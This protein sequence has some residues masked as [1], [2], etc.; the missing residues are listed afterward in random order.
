[1]MLFAC[2]SFP[3]FPSPRV[4][5]KASMDGNKV[6]F[7]RVIV[8][9]DLTS[10]QNNVLFA[11]AQMREPFTPISRVTA[12]PITPVVVRSGKRMWSV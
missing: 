12:I 3:F 6:C 4:I 9:K 10:D 8:V 11:P 1:M 2:I 5:C 7:Q